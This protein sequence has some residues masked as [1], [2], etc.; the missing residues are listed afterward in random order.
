[1]TKREPL[2]RKKVEEPDK[3]G[4]HKKKAEPALHG[5]LEVWDEG[6]AEFLGEPSAER[7]AALLANA[8]SDEHRANLAIHLQQYY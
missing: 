3:E 8:R 2:G 4:G 1:M 6:I 5:R 7:H